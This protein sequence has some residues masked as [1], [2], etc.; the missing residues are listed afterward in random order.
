M[1]RST[2]LALVALGAILALAVQLPLT[3]IDLRLTGLILMLTGLAGLRAPQRAYHWLR[4]HR[5]EL[6][7]ALERFMAPAPR[8]PRVPLDTLLR[9]PQ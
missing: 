2:G 8:D 6:A 7:E 3:F 9:R 4:G 1:K 5:D